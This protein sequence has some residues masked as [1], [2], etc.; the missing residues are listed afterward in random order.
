MQWRCTSSVAQRSSGEHKAT[1]TGTPGGRRTRGQKTI[2]P[3]AICSPGHKNI[4]FYC[5]GLPCERTHHGKGLSQVTSFFLFFLCHQ[6]TPTR[7]LFTL[8]HLFKASRFTSLRSTNNYRNSSN[9]YQLRE[10]PRGGAE[11]EVPA[12]RPAMPW[13]L[14][15]ALQPTS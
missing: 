6:R 14:H 13:Q 15:R 4:F 8:P 10:I 7:R 2:N 11:E 9:N 5:R 3:R 12:G 1:G